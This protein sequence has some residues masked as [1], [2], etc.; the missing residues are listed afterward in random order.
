MDTAQ[1]KRRL[2][3]FLK[4][5]TIRIS[6]KHHGDDS[7][8]AY[9]IDDDG[10]SQRSSNSVKKDS[11]LRRIGRGIREWRSKRRRLRGDTR[12]ENAHNLEGKR[13]SSEESISERSFDI[14]DFSD[15]DEPIEII[16]EEVAVQESIEIIHEDVAVQEGAKEQQ[17]N[18]KGDESETQSREEVAQLRKEVTLPQ[19]W[20]SPPTPIYSSL[21]C[22]D[23][24]PYDKSLKPTKDIVF[25]R[26]RKGAFDFAQSTLNTEPAFWTDASHMPVRRKGCKI[27]HHGGI[28]VAH[29]LDNRWTVHSAHTSGLT[30]IKQLEK[31]AI[32][33]A[34]HMALQEQKSG[35]LGE[36][37]VYICSDSDASLQ[38]IENVGKYNRPDQSLAALIGRFILEQYCEL[39]RLGYWVE[40]HWVPGH[41]WLPGNEL[42]DRVSGLSCWWLA[43][44]APSSAQGTG[45]VIPLEVRTFDEP[46]HSYCPHKSQ[47]QYDR[48]GA[49]QLLE[50]TK[51]LQVVLAPN[52]PG[53][54]SCNTASVGRVDGLALEPAPQDTSRLLQAPPSRPS[55]EIGE[56]KLNVSK[57]SSGTE[58]PPSHNMA[59]GLRQHTGPILQPPPPI[60][61]PKLKAPKNKQRGTGPRAYK[62]LCTY[63]GHPGHLIDQCFEKFPEQKLAFP[64]R[65]AH[66][67]GRPRLEKVIPGA[68]YNISRLHPQ[69]MSRSIHRHDSMVGRVGLSPQL[70]ARQCAV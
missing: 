11:K 23:L 17:V 69:L 2:K 52:A 47:P 4:H 56:T 61:Q 62:R 10:R 37:T 9:S 64:Q 20:L 67:V 59:L 55:S 13:F 36:G 44:A 19:T 5:A 28:A 21:V 58:T 3:A 35:L 48:A 46:W 40:F 70:T 32:V 12:P 53:P 45:L 39:R 31:L 60:A 63:C 29:K 15:E 27:E 16:H 8:S 34:L 50:N 14:E 6:T 30:N 26:D 25:R 43:K 33:M 7:A 1:P 49:L 51:S 65:Y 54:E 66:Y 24:A 41:S 38:W 42:A 18:P 68:F 57:P 22:Q